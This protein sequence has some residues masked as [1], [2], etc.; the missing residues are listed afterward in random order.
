MARTAMTITNA[1]SSYST[2]GVDVSALA[3][4]DNTN[5][6]TFPPTGRE[7]LVVQ[8]PTGGALTLTVHSAADQAG[9][10]GDISAHSIAAG[11][12]WFSQLFKAD[13]WA[14]S[15]GLVNV[16]ASGAGLLYVLLRFPTSN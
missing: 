9:R 11:A 2:T 16:D 8:N 10:T 4:V 6:M 7:L 13:G 12:F 15:T 5:G 1:A 14:Q 3:S